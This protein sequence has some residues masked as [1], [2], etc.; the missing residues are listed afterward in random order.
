MTFQKCCACLSLCL[1]PW[2]LRIKSSSTICFTSELKRFWAGRFH[3]WVE[4]RSLTGLVPRS[5]SLHLRMVAG[6]KIERKRRLIHN[7]SKTGLCYADIKAVCYTWLYTLQQIYQTY[8][9][10]CIA[11]LELIQ[12]R[13]P[14]QCYSMLHLVVHLTADLPNL[15]STVHSIIGTD[16]TKGSYSV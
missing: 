12:Q 8:P 9:V 11:S 6:G 13:D 4:S 3:I 16:P 1:T 5:G 10:L 15:P 2:H 7:G 14:T